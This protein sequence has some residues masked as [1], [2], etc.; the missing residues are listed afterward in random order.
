MG[1]S[2]GGLEQKPPSWALAPGCSTPTKRSDGGR[3]PSLTHSRTSLDPSLGTPS[4]AVLSEGAEHPPP[5]PGPCPCPGWGVLGAE[6]R[7]RSQGCGPHRWTLQPGHPNPAAL[8][9]A[10]PAGTPGL[11]LPLITAAPRQDPT[12]LAYSHRWSLRAGQTAHSAPRR[13]PSACT[14]GPHCLLQDS[15][16]S[17]GQALSEVLKGP[18]PPLCPGQ[19]LS[20]ATPGGTSPGARGQGWG[21]SAEGRGWEDRFPGS[22]ETLSRPSMEGQ[23][24]GRPGWDLQGLRAGSTQAR[25]PSHQPSSHRE[26]AQPHSRKSAPQKIHLLLN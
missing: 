19:V 20:R 4:A 11:G 10:D 25:T 18:S 5:V 21:G 1:L 14:R 3:R 15:R 6:S 12:L 8:H 17:L 26:M 23:W 13:L 22:A 16:T 9:E 7:G 24:Q 2:L